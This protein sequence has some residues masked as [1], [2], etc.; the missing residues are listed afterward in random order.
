MLLQQ[1][2][3]DP[4]SSRQLDHQVLKERLKEQGADLEASY[5]ESMEL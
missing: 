3:H 4:R 2:E 1:E 5:E